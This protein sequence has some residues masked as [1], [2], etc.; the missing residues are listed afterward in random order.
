MYSQHYNNNNTF[1]KKNHLGL[2]GFCNMANK[3]KLKSNKQTNKSNTSVKLQYNVHKTS[4][5]KFSIA[6]SAITVRNP[7]SKKRLHTFSPALRGF[8]GFCYL[9]QKAS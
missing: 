6:V 9:F 5:C 4:H 3:E 8:H 2:H 1:L 7:S